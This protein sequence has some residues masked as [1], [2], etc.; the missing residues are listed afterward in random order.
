MHA[1][2]FPKV[3]AIVL[4]YNGKETLLE[5]IQ[6]L[7]CSSYQNL[8]IV[9]VDNAST[10]DSLVL[11]KKKYPNIHY[12]VNSKNI[13]FSSGNNVGIR[14]AL[15][16]FADYV[17]LLNNDA[18]VTKKSIANMVAFAEKD[19]RI[20]IMSP[21]ILNHDG[22]QIWFSGGEINWLRMRAMHRHSSDLV[23]PSSIA[24][25]TGCAM[26]IGKRT[27]KKIGLFDEDY[28]L[29]YED[30]DFSLRARKNNFSVL[31]FPGAKVFHRE[32][33]NQKNSRKTYWLVFSALLFFKKHSPIWIQ[34]W[35]FFYFIIRK[36]KNLIDCT[37][38]KKNDC[39]LT[40]EAY[41]DFASYEK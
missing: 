26:L 36:Y 29:Y 35:H 41:M 25:A 2:K 10:D 31:F 3:F 7:H 14:F 19:S 40:R 21:L 15:E 11:A 8:E 37:L 30:V 24:Y 12:I 18:W 1:E 5:C 32:D 38:D 6:S 17:F 27:F 39:V 23:N 20:G 9:I 33:S 22:S 34:I 16:K 13:G 4:N 28:F